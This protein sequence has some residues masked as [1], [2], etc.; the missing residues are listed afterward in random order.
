MTARYHSGMK[1]KLSRS[2]NYEHLASDRKS[3]RKRARS[4]APC[5][6][7]KLEKLYEELCRLREQVQIAESRERVRLRSPG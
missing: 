4:T 6:A 3:G 5:P 2:E 7:V 1:P